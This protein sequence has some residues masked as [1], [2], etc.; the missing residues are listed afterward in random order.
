MQGHFQ[1]DLG[2]HEEKVSRFFNGKETVASNTLY[3]V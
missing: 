2:F 1:I 3:R